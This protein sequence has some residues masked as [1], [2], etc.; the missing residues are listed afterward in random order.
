MPNIVQRDCV[1][2]SFQHVQAPKCIHTVANVLHCTHSA[3]CT[4]LSMSSIILTVFPRAAQ[5]NKTAT[6]TYMLLVHNPHKTYKKLIPIS[7]FLPPSIVLGCVHWVCREGVVPSI[8][9][10]GYGTVTDMNIYARSHMHR[11]KNDYKTQ[12]HLTSE[13]M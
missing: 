12:T 8:L 13:V 3:T 9:P 5:T 7:C 11:H 6:N 1:L 2:C 4:H 10:W